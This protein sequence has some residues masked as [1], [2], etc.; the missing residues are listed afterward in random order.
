MGRKVGLAM[1]RHEITLSG[2]RTL[3]LVLYGVCNG[4]K[5]KAVVLQWPR[6]AGTGSLSMA[7]AAGRGRPRQRLALQ[8]GSLGLERPAGAPS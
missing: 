8:R 2:S 1:T 6:G 5:K 4:T 7:G 3:V